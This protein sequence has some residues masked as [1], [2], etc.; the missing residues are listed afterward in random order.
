M[1]SSSYTEEIADKICEIIATSNRSM[2]SILEE[3]DVAY[4][5]HLQWLRDHE[6]YR[7]KY[8]QAKEDQADFLAEEIISI[9]D[10]KEGDTIITEDGKA[11]V[12]YEN[13]SRARLRVDSRKFIAAKL[14]PKKY[15]DK[16]QT[17]ITSDGEKVQQVFVI[18]GKEIRFE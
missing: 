2:K 18:G 10:D 16:I 1:R 8:A 3:I 5:T 11:I 17:D 4:G 7:I 6:S 15:G 9:A 14:K 12:V 13:I